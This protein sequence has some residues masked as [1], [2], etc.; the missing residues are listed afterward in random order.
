MFSIKL[1]FGDSFEPFLNLYGKRCLIYVLQTFL[2]LLLV[3]DFLQC[4][5]NKSFQKLE[6]KRGA[7]YLSTFPTR[8]CYNIYRIDYLNFCLISSN[9]L[10]IRSPFYNDEQLMVLFQFWIISI[11][12]FSFYCA[13]VTP[14]CYP[15]RVVV[16]PYC[17]TTENKI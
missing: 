12:C 14:H 7:K 1:R 16:S 9:P 11:I 15:L 3:N 6:P 4:G 13:Q 5:S 17:R 2:F 8:I 10:K